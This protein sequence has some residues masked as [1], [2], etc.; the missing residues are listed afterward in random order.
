MREEDRKKTLCAY[1][2]NHRRLE[3]EIECCYGSEKGGEV[4]NSKGGS[5]G[6]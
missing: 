4:A 2:E 6:G 3:K 5:E 1:Y